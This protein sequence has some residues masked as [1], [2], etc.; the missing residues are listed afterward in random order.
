MRPQ[1]GLP[2]ALKALED[3]EL[4]KQAQKAERPVDF[5]DNKEVEEW[6][7]DL[8][9]LPPDMVKTIKKAYGSS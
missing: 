9:N 4:L 7:R 3:P 8:L 2:A 5:V 1:D 6:S